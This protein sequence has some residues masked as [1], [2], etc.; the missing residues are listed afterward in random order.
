MPGAQRAAS[1]LTGHRAA[2]SASFVASVSL[3]FFL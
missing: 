2:L 3:F 1:L